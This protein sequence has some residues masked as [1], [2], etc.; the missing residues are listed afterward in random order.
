LA[1]SFDAALLHY[2]IELRRP[3]LDD[4]MLFASAIGAG[5]FIWWVTALIAAVF[6]DKRAAAWRM[7]VAIAFTFAINDYVLKPLFD[8]SRPY[9]VDSTITII[10]AKPDTPALPSGHAA[11]AVAGAMA[12]SR[13]IPYSAW[14]WWP[15]AMVIAVSRVYIGVHWPTDVIAGALFGCAA[16]WFV[17]GGRDRR[18]EEKDRHDYERWKA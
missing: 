14:F 2:V 7:L 3:W 13:L 6:P 17:L 8:R 16:A 12:G 1:S 4:V 18:R 10:D 15:L 11:M 9:Q 5:A